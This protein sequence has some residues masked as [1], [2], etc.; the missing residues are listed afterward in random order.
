MS[1]CYANRGLAKILDGQINNGIGDINQ[2]L[3]IDILQS[4]AYRSL[5]INQLNH[6]NYHT[7]IQYFRIA[8]KY[9]TTTFGIDELIDECLKNILGR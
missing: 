6:K 4:Y 8:Y 3:N 1:Y 2:S 7:A 9:D 5:G